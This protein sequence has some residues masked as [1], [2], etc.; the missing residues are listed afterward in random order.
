MRH[1]YVAVA[2]SRRSKPAVDLTLT[3][4]PNPNPNPNPNPSPNPNPNPNP[5]Q[6]R[7]LGL[8]VSPVAA[9]RLLSTAPLEPVRLDTRHLHVRVS[10]P[11]PSPNLNHDPDQVRLD[12][13]RLH[14]RVSYP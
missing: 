6:A 10:E 7:L 2:P 1:L 14:V 9:Q 5:N 8:G 11:Y 3:L 12:T 4:T 13:R